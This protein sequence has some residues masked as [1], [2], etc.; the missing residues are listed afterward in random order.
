MSTSSHYLSTVQAGERLGISRE[1][2]RRLI[3]QGELR[4]EETVNGF[5]VEAEDVAR[6]AAERQ[7]RQ[8]ERAQRDFRSAVNDLVTKSRR[9]EGAEVFGS[10]AAALRDEVKVRSAFEVPTVVAAQ[11]EW[12]NRQVVAN[13]AF[14]VLQ[15]PVKAVTAQWQH[16]VDV[17]HALEKVVDYDNR[18]TTMTA[19]SFASQ[20]AKIE[21][22]PAQPTAI[23]A[24]IEQA[25]ASEKALQDAV[26]FK[27]NVVTQDFV[28]R[29]NG[30]HITQG[31]LD[32]QQASIK[33]AQDN[34]AAT[35]KQQEEHL[36]NVARDRAQAKTSPLG[37]GTVMPTQ[38][39]LE[40]AQKSDRQPQ[41]EG[42]MIVARSFAGSA[43]CNE[44]MAREFVVPESREA[45]LEEK[46][47]ELGRKVEELTELVMQQRADT[48]A[49]MPTWQEWAGSDRPEDVLAKLDAIRA[50]VTSGKQAGEN[51]TDV[52][53]EARE[54]RGQDE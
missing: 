15:E 4:A 22:Q 45:R 25:N 37:V 34:I 12:M 48:A 24:L 40:E 39:Y 10:A 2:V 21:A 23:K 8:V 29:Q 7:I 44:E 26:S 20:T 53:R 49:A 31:F 35:W 9:V 47:D 36:T 27:P 11:V 51:S 17:Y 1:H 41:K 42:V 14:T 16:M 19:D 30:L 5:M 54:A 52:I 18:L 38:K 28:D 33:V 43:V 32:R 46:M 50:G 13:T 3:Q 6:L